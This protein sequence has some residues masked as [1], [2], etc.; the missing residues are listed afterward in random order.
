VRTFPVP[1]AT[2]RHANRTR[3]AQV[4]VAASADTSTQYSIDRYPAIDAVNAETE[5]LVEATGDIVVAG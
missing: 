4:V 5:A 2:A 3:G 1:G